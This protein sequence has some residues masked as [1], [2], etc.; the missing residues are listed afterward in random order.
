MKKGILTFVLVAVLALSFVPSFAAGQKSPCL[1][2][3][4]SWLIPGLGQVYN[5]Q[6]GKGAV[7]FGASA[8]G[9]T[10]AIIGASGT[11]TEDV[12]I[13]YNYDGSPIYSQEE[14]SDPNEPLMY[15]GIAVA[16]VA[17]CRCNSSCF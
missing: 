1:A 14:V 2:G 12:L 17:D 15:G 9:I 11:K 7:F 4:L 8:V 5:E 16:T 10:L 6:Y 13:G 3:G